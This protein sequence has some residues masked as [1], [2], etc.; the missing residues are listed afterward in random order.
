MNYYIFHL[1]R[2]EFN[3]ALKCET[4]RMRILVHRVISDN[5]C[6]NFANK[7]SIPHN[8]FRHSAA[9]Y[10]VFLVYRRELRYSQK[11][12]GDGQTIGYTGKYSY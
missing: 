4:H 3:F 6:V 1:F 11:D 5:D 9:N 7:I 10:N 12:K 2:V 8:T